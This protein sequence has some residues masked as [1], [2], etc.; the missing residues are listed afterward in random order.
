VPR[1]TQRRE[2]ERCVISKGTGKAGWKQKRLLL[3]EKLEVIV[4]PRIGV[5]PAKLQNSASNIKGSPLKR[6]EFCSFAGLTPMRG[7]SVVP[8]C[9]S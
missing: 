2:D 7:A 5:R 6:A 9:I 4:E 1:G 3:I 8:I